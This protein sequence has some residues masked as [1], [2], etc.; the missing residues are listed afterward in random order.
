MDTLGYGDMVWQ[1]VTEFRVRTAIYR[2]PAIFEAEMQKIFERT[3]IYIGHE[4][5]VEH[6]GDYRT[7]SIGRQ[8]IIWSR[9]D[10]G[11]I[12]VLFNSCRHRGNAVCRAE[13]GNSHFF[14][15]P[16]HGWIYT[17]SGSLVGVTERGGYA[18]GSLKDVSGLIK[19]PRVAVYRGLIFAS[20]SPAGESIEEYLGPV[21]KYVDLWADR[22]PVG[23]VHVLRPH[24]FV[25][26]GNWKFQVE[27]G[28]DGYHPNFVHESAF[29]TLEQ[30]GLRNGSNRIPGE[31]GSSMGFDYGH[32]WLSG[33]YRQSMPQDLFK[34]YME[35]LAAQYGSERAQEVTKNRH[36]LLFPNVYLMD[37]N[38]RVIQPVSADKTVVYSSYTRLEG[39][40]DD[41]NRA[42]LQDLQRRLGTT[43]F[44]SPDDMEMFAANQTGMQASSME[45]LILSR[46]MNRERVHPSGE[47]EAL[48]SDETPQRAIYRE[49][50]RLM[51]QVR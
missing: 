12:H 4:S 48:Y 31:V 50:D 13:R 7:G 5:E 3:W 39:V 36:I 34:G 18:D 19:V 23:K 10:D 11:Q 27:N 1:D 45:W 46:G 43:G 16:Y 24:K 42:R 17:N 8:P 28:A 29:K 49:W 32:C 40:S 2:D 25:Y 51:N 30:F 21:R 6:P 26:P 41:V 35:S 22:S 47:R 44:I 20:L 37:V 15:C 38:V 9:G 14:Q 33:A